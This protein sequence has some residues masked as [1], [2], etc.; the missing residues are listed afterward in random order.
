MKKIIK[1][2][3]LWDDK[4]E[5]VYTDKDLIECI[6]TLSAQVKEFSRI[7][8]FFSQISDSSGEVLLYMLSEPYRM[9][10]QRYL[11]LHEINLDEESWKDCIKECQRE[12]SLIKRHFPNT[13]VT[14]NFR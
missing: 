10:N 3:R 6:K 5:I 13:H 12:K 2:D 9:D 1:S 7:T 4:E 14:S 11:K 8:M